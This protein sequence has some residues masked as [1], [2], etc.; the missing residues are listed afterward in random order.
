MIK[1]FTGTSPFSGLTDTLAIQ[2]I[3]YGGRPGRPQGQ[4]LTD[5]IWYMTTRCW[6]EDPLLRPKMMEVLETKIASMSW[7]LSVREQLRSEKRTIQEY[8]ERES[9]CE[10]ITEYGNR[11]EE[12]RNVYSNRKLLQF[13]VNGKCFSPYNMSTST[14]FYLSQSWVFHCSCTTISAPQWPV[15][16]DHPRKSG[17]T[18]PELGLLAATGVPRYVFFGESRVRKHGLRDSTNGSFTHS[19]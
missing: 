6:Q 8:K 9:V 3:I 12:L 1:V 11:T 15:S 16:H 19:S 4:D 17:V 18:V 5:P 13:Y 2:Q 7:I 10:D 14:C